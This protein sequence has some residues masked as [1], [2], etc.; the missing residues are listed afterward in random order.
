MR[1]IN[2]MIIP[3]ILAG[4]VFFRLGLYAARN[5]AGRACDRLLAAGSLLL[6]APALL[7]LL[8]YFHFRF[9]DGAQW[10]Y[11][12]RA[13]PCSELAAGGIFFGTGVLHAR[14][15]GPFFRSLR[16]KLYA[17]LLLLAPHLKPLLFPLDNN[18]LGERWSQD[19]C[20]QS[21][22]ATCGPCSGATLLRA[23][24]VKAGERELAYESFSYR[25]GTEAW[26]LARALKRRGL[27]VRLLAGGAV[28]AELPYPSI[29]GVWLGGQGRMGHFITVLDKTSQ[30]YIIGEPLQGRRILSPKTLFE[31]YDF[32]G[33]FL[34]A[35]RRR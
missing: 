35:R 26:Y 30:G 4:G 17:L 32:T 29:A 18:I 7:F 8:Y 31:T 25:L 1:H 19:V 23:F 22:P 11:V 15:P 12:F 16:F 34:V 20:L 5:C 9:L 10:F 27:D 21:T 24:G 33:F 14:A 6:A 3:A 2:P 13:A 28:P